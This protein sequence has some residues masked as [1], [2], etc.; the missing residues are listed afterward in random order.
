VKKALKN[1]ALGQMF[2]AE[3]PVVIVVVSD[4][5][6]SA[7]QCHWQEGCE[8]TSRGPERPKNKQAKR[9]KAKKKENPSDFAQIF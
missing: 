5:R 8:L 4:T 3:A 2:I 1:A 9:R 7:A 6:R